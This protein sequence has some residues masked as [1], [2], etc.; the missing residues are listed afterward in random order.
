MFESR[1]LSTDVQ[2]MDRRQFYSTHKT[3]VWTTGFI[4]IILLLFTC[5]LGINILRRR[6]TEATLLESEERMKSALASMEDFVFVLDKECVFESFY[7]PSTSS[8]LYVS[9]EEFLG[10]SYKEIMPPQVV[11]IFDGAIDKVTR[12]G[13]VERVYYQLGMLQETRCFS[14]NISIRKDGAGRNA[15]FTVVSRDVTERMRA[16]ESLRE[17][18]ARLDSIIRV[19]VL[20]FPFS[21][22]MH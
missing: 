14:A 17:Q 9:S 1:K 19:G 8:G 12:T 3:V 18:Q 5:L 16:E 2:F 13:G 20:I 22:T 6:R 11:K 21:I 15:G 10:R 4:F 7:Q